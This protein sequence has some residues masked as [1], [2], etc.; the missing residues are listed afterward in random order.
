MTY[1]VSFKDE[2]ERNNYLRSLHAVRVPSAGE[3]YVTLAY[4]RDGHAVE[5]L[6]QQVLDLLL[7][8][9]FLGFHE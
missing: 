3:M 4:G 2:S 9:E 5:G 8:V 1:S 7:L 6:I